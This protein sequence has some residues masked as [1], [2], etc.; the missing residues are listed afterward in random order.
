[1]RSA[2]NEPTTVTRTP[3]V[4]GA[5]ETSAPPTRPTFPTC[6]TSR[7]TPMLSDAPDAGI[8]GCQE[9]EARRRSRREDRSQESPRQRARVDACANVVATAAHADTKSTK[10]R[11]IL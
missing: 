4:T 1:M 10:T 3:P 2:A 9:R 7:S 8:A 5:A 6:P 11:E